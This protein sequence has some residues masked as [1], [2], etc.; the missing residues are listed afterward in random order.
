[1]QRTAPAFDRSD[2]SANPS[3]HARPLLSRQSRRPRILVA[4]DNEA[5]A[6]TLAWGLEAYGC[7]VKAC[8][9]GREAIA[10]IHTFQP[11]AIL[12][13]LGMPVMGGLAACHVMRTELGLTDTL[14]I[15]QTAW[16]DLRSREET[17]AAGFD[18][19]LVKPLNL[20]EVDREIRQRISPQAGDSN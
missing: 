13:D 20:E 1:M 7:E 6:I 8:F 9:N 2:E 19:H 18:L 15:A 10:M 3:P 16:G 4:D 17:H 11:D 12:L 14:I 5:S